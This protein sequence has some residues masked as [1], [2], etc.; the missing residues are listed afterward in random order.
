VDTVPALPEAKVAQQTA[1]LACCC[2]LGWMG[3][4]ILAYEWYQSRQ[5]RDVYPGELAEAVR[6]KASEMAALDSQLPYF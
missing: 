2:M 5:I 6:R 3:V 4:L 1:K